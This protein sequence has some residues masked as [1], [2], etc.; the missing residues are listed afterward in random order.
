MN[1]G[2]W[3]M[4]DRRTPELGYNREGSRGTVEASVFERSSSSDALSSTSGLL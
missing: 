3:S 2:E 1:G 4:R